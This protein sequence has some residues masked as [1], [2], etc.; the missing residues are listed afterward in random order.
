MFKKLKH[1][2][3]IG[4]QRIE[5]MEVTPRMASNWLEF[6]NTN[7]RK[8][9]PTKVDFY[10]D[11]IRRGKWEYNGNTLKFD[12][13]GVMY[14]G[15]HRCHAVILA[16]RAI[17]TGVA[18]GLA[19]PAKKTIDAVPPRSNADVIR[20]GGGFSDV[21]S[22]HTATLSAMLSSGNPAPKQATDLTCAAMKKHL[23][24]IQFA[25]AALPK[26]RGVSNGT[27]CAVVARAFYSTPVENLTTFCEMLSTGIGCT[28]VVS[29]LRDFLV[30]ESGG[31]SRAEKVARYGKTE[32]ALVAFLKGENPR[33]LYAVTEEQFP[34][35]EEV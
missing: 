6:A 2:P 29:R 21:N 22:K 3:R 18:F 9:S 34:L 15:Q 17:V 27:V 7:N 20:I 25:I 33:H 14:D 13:R 12:K 5:L 26:G 4:E 24:A 32:R 30:K 10:A 11:Q 35:P 23:P 31:G 8:L 19:A 28:S 1:L 16:D